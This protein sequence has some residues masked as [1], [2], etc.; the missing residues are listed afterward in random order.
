LQ[1]EHVEARTALTE[2]LRQTNL[3]LDVAN[4]AKAR[5]LTSMGHELR[6]PLNAILGFTGTVLMGL[7]GPLSDDQTH[8]LRTVQS[9]GRHLLSLINDLLDLATIESGRDE[10]KIEPIDGPVLRVRWP[11]S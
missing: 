11:G 9:S 3:A 10:L 5:F 8:Q 6:T 4:Q 7:A 2:Q 1:A